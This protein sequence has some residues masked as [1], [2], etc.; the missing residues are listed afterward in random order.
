MRAKGASMRFYHLVAVALLALAWSGARSCGLLQPM[1]ARI[2][3]SFNETRAKLGGAPVSYQPPPPPEYEEVAGCAFPGLADEAQLVLLSTHG[4]QSI[5]SVTLASQDVAVGAG[6]L[7]IE[8]GD[9]PL[10]V[11]LVSFEPVIW[12]VSGAVNRVR[13]LVLASEE[14][15]RAIG[16]DAPLVGV[17]GLAADQV[18]ILPNRKCLR[19][20]GTVSSP[21]AALAEGAM[22]HRVSRKPNIMAADE[23]VGGFSVPSGTILQATTTGNSLL[24]AVPSLL[25]EW[26]GMRTPF[27]TGEIELEHDMAEFHPGGVMTVDARQVMSPFEAAPYRVLP[28]EAGLLQLVRQGDLSLGETGQLVINHPIRFPAGMSGAHSRHFLLAAGVPLPSGDAGHSCVLSL[29]T[30]KAILDDGLC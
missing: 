26:V 13:H 29:Q 21:Q 10:Y 3:G 22:R 6:K 16:S 27:H 9:T 18:S 7:V 15:N 8:E 23:Y 4:A 17:T 11:V 5:S 19:Y 28:Q 20:F 1:T 2:P 12:Q 25:L 14:S 30:G 24:R